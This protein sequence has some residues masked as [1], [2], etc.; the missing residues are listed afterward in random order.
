MGTFLLVVLIIIL[1]LLAT[2]VGVVVGMFSLTLLTARAAA[3]LAVG[4]VPEIKIKELGETFSRLVEQQLSKEYGVT[5]AQISYNMDVEFPD[6][7]V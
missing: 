5:G 3:A 7:E 4:K 1:M 6:G 2:F